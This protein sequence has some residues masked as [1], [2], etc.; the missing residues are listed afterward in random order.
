MLRPLLWL[1]WLPWL[2][3]GFDETQ[4]L[5]RVAS[6]SSAARGCSSPLVKYAM[7]KAPKELRNLRWVHFPKAG[8]SF[9]TT[10]WQFACGQR[11]VLDLSQTTFNH[12]E[13]PKLPYKD[14]VELFWP[15]RIIMHRYPR[16]RYCN[17][18]VFGHQ[19]VQTLHSPVSL[20][21]MDQRKWQVIAMFRKPSQRLLSAFYYN[22]MFAPGI[23]PRLAELHEKCDRPACFARFPGIAGCYARMLTNSTCAEQDE[24]SFDSGKARL[25]EALQVL[26]AMSF[27]GLSEKWDLSIC[28]FHRMFGG[29]VNIG[30][31]Q[32]L[33]KGPAHEESYNESLLEGFE[34]E[35]D[36]AI[37]RAAVEKFQGLL[38]EYVG[39]DAE[40]AC[41]EILNPP[42]ETCSCAKVGRECGFDPGIGLDCGECP[43]A[44]LRVLGLD[45][46]E[47][48]LECS[49]EGRCII[50]EEEEGLF[51]W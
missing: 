33:H 41:G 36:E 42:S 13:W 44:R 27:V 3:T 38:R 5:Q 9:V 20:K 34:D 14:E 51:Q 23:G 37:Y 21:E 47:T 6:A 45:P 49:A 4:L 28:L 39:D 31:L 24:D 10:L 26:H 2:V 16:G 46:D 7:P 11:D 48:A 40:T 17:D 12:S 30:Q 19:N 43:R 18:E 32:D 8:W 35:V 1:P 22:G 50:E 25:P 29:K 15:D